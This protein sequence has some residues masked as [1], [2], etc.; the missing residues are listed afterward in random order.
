MKKVGLPATPLASGARH[1]LGD[2]RGE[3]APAQALAQ[4][5]RHRVR[6]ARR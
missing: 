6:A 2:P 1:V 4:T 3:A 5:D